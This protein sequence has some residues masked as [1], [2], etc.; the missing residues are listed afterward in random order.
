MSTG[1]DPKKGAALSLWR[2]SDAASRSVRTF[3]TECGIPIGNWLVCCGHH[4]PGRCR[5]ATPGLGGADE[6]RQRNLQ[7]IVNN[8]RF[9]IL[10]WVRVKGLAS[11]TL[12]MS[13]RIMPRDWEARY[14]HRPLLVETPVNAARSRDTCYRAANWIH[15]GQTT[16]RGRMDREH[17][18]HGTAFKDIYIYPLVHDFQHR[19]CSDPTR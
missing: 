5:P 12:A 3:A 17:Q 8:G 2:S 18:K 6:Q 11:K 4:P 16:G 15:V 7:S 13:A 9:L 1:E 10:P 14:G 19:P